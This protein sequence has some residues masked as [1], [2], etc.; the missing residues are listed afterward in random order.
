[1]NLTDEQ[2]KIVDTIQE[3]DVKLIKVDAVAGL[4]KLYDILIKKE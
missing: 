2:Q 1:V 3:P 4:N